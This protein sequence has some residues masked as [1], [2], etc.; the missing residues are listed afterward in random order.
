MNATAQLYTP[1][2]LGLAVTLADYPYDPSFP[3][4]GQARSASC[5]S[6]MDLGFVL[7]R[8]SRIESI[9]MKVHACAVGQA[10]AAVFAAQANGLRVDDIE[11]VHD[12]LSHWLAGEGKL[13]DWSGLSI[14][15]PARAFPGRHGAIMLPWRA[16]LQA[17]SNIRRAR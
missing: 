9:G 7:D 2:L 3:M 16:A 10:A 14:I 17:L 5:G 15:E 6:T 8:A 12:A 1:E 13:P 11:R 4:Q